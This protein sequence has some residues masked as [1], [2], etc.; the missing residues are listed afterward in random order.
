MKRGA[1]HEHRGEVRGYSEALNLKGIAYEKCDQLIV[2]KDLRERKATMEEKPPAL[3]LCRRLWYFRGILEIIT[4]KQ[5]RYHNKPIVIFNV[6]G[7]Y[8]GLIEIFENIIKLNFA[9][10]ESRDLYFVADN[11][12]EA[13]DYIEN[14]QPKEIASKWLTHVNQD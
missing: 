12:T 3:S 9:K 5:L 13:L 14:Y 8:N 11:V 6:D 4:L 1:I 2:T 10:K 7:F